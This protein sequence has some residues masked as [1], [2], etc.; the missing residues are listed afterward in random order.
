MPWA[1]PALE[2]GKHPL[3]P[4]VETGHALGNVKGVFMMTFVQ[5]V[6]PTEGLEPPTV[7]LQI[8]ST[9]SYATL[10]SDHPRRSPLMN[11]SAVQ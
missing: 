4:V 3:F 7:G 2:N 11:A 6:E 1:V 9:T 10:A 8:R 5:Y